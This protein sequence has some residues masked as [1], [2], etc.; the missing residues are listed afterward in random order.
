VFAVICIAASLLA[1][2]GVLDAASHILAPVMRAFDLPAQAALPV[3]LASVR[4]DGIFLFAADEGLA[5]PL[6]AAQTLTAVYLAGV[7]L[8]CLVTALTI[9]RETTWRSTGKF[10]IRQAA[11]GILFSAVLAWGGRWLL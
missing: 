4:K 9:G 10:L 5:M 2:F 6:T 1:Q 11:F 3:V 7:L 8:P